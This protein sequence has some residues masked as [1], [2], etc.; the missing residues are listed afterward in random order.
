ML[1]FSFHNNPSIQKDGINI[2]F[3]NSEKK[4]PTFLENKITG[5]NN[6]L[7]LFDD[8]SGKY[9]DKLVTCIDIQGSVKKFMFC[10]IGNAGDLTKVKIQEIGGC[11]SA[12]LN[13]L[14]IK[15]ANIII[16]NKELKNTYNLFAVNIAEGIKLRNY[17]FNK[18]FK[19][20]AKKHQIYLENV[21][22]YIKDLDAMVDFSDREKIVAGT[23]FARDLVSEPGNVLTPEEFTNVAKDL[24]KLGVKIKILNKRHLKSLKMNALLAVGQGSCNDPY[25]VIMEWN[26]AKSKEKPI[27]F[28]GKGVT[29]DTGGINLKPSGPSI[30]KM[31]YDMG[32]AA[33]VTALMMSL[34]ARK[35]KVNVVGAIGLAENMPS[36]TAQRPSDVITSM[37]GQTIEVDNTDAEGRLL[38]ADVMWYTQEN[39]KPKV[40]IDLATLTGAI[41]M[42]LGYHNAGLFSNDDTLSN[43]LLKAGIETGEKLW[44]LPLSEY[45]DGLI[46]SDIAD[47]KNTGKNGAG[48]ITAA[49]FLKR[50][51]QKDC[52]WAHIDIAGVNW[53][54]GGNKVSPK[55]ASGYG[56]RLL[57]EFL[58]KNYENK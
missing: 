19:Y 2:I 33:V 4:L 43:Q 30:T 10:G 1:S 27:A 42:A 47:I 50:F 48:S 12:K 34:A 57:N 52:A 15:H 58:L 11:I 16:D 17:C 39:F 5:I 28:V 20:E 24:K 53:L 29:F 54:D 31:K 38:L 21:D 51:V 55:G 37:S 45:Y 40:M 25:V 13:S 6:V 32:G 9:G 18:Y 46:N 7:K 8:F 3:L 49:Q 44:R 35:A 23:H 26:G 36:G 56:V 14:K 22:F 41:I